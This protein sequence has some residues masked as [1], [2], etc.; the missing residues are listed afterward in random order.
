MVIAAL[1]R[2]NL[3]ARSTEAPQPGLEWLEQRRYDLV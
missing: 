3:P 2:A 1:R